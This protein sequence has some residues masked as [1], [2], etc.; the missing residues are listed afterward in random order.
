VIRYIARHRIDVIHCEEGWRNG[1]YAFVLSRVTRAKYI[2]HF[3]SKYGSWMSP[4]SR[5]ATQRADAII[6]VSS[7]T[8]RVIHE[9][10][11]PRERIFPVLNGI[12]LNG[13][14]PEAVTGDGVRREFGLQPGAPLIVMVAQ[15]TAWKRQSTLVEAF[16]TVIL[17]HPAAHLLLV[18]VEWN[19]SRAPREGGYTQELRRLVTE[20][21]LE[22]HVSFAGQRR[23]VREI[24]A[25]ADIFTLP[26][27]DD[28]CALA[29]IEAMV[30]AKPIVAVQAGGTP[31][32][33]EHGKTGLLGPPD[34][35]ERLA[36]NLTALI[37]DPVRRREMGEQGRRRAVEYLNARRV[38]ADV[39]G[40]YRFVAGFELG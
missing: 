18:G 6:A 26:S 14:D 27:V 4:L 13:W 30:M 33:V 23:D 21:G 19:W 12:D 15:L 9:A 22:R 7:W 20:A 40:V 29:Y 8:G 31:E 2:V 24:L 1:F 39:E 25:A 35:S 3:H 11:V 16:R 28:P 17:K 36:S 10:G 37:D 5:L 32:L 34:D 38:A